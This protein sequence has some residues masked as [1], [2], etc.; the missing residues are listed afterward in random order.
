[1]VLSHSPH[2]Q[3][4][5]PQHC[6]CSTGSRRGH[7]R[8]ANPPILLQTSTSSKLFKHATWMD[9]ED[10]SDGW[11]DVWSP[12]SCTVKAC[13]PQHTVVINPVRRGH[14]SIRIFF[15]TRKVTAF[16]GFLPQ[17]NIDPWLSKASPQH[18]S[19][20]ACTSARPAQTVCGR[21]G[22][23]GAGPGSA[24]G[25]R[26]LLV[27]PWLTQAAGNDGRWVDVELSGDLGYLREV[28]SSGRGGRGDY[29]GGSVELKDPRLKEPLWPQTGPEREKSRMNKPFSEEQLF[30]RGWCLFRTF[31][32]RRCEHT[33]RGL[34]NQKNIIADINSKNKNNLATK[35]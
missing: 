25:T 33:H 11:L 12:S 6:H 17:V 16:I 1:M 27:L 32:S 3:Q 31:R 22:R 34:S 35:R 19:P 18:R 29:R 5:L 7:G 8:Q 10:T 21:H 4:L 23:W 26:E 20:P 2:N 30:K 28:R 15:L 13:V 14:Q 9:L 24:S